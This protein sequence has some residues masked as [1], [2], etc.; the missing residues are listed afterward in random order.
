MKKIMILC[1]SLFLLVACGKPSPIKDINE[2]IQSLLSSNNN[3]IHYINNLSSVEAQIQKAFDT[4]IN[5]ELLNDENSELLKI[6]NQQKLDME[7]LESYLS[8]FEN[9]TTI[10]NE[11]DL[12]NLEKGNDELEKL[13]AS[14]TPLSETIKTSTTSF[15]EQFETTSKMVEIMKQENPSIQD[16]NDSLTTLNATIVKVHE[17]LNKLGEQNAVFQNALSNW[18]ESLKSEEEVNT[19]QENEV[20]NETPVEPV[21]EEPVVESVK[22]EYTLDGNFMVRHLDTSKTDKLVLLTF[23]D[24]VQPEGSSYSLEIAKVL[25]EKGVYGLFFV[26]GMFI[27]SDFGKD[28]LKQI[29]DLGH[30]IGNHTYSHPYL[31]TLDLQQTKDELVNTN[32]IIESVITDKVKFFRPSYGIMGDYSQQVIDELN[33]TWMNWTYGYDWEADYMNGDSLADIMVNTP[34]LSDGA[35]LLMHDRKWTA[36]AIGRIVDGLIAKGYTIVDPRLIEVGGQ[37]Q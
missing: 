18:D 17:G 35:N 29:H 9:A 26:N 1:A 25:K 24:V 32:N 16:L 27:E 2:T 22:A 7:N 11:I 28:Q 6:V 8:S 23:D 19:P 36:E 21:I 12:E 37:T 10:L 20:V 33:M 5:Q 3:I 31:N 15:K 14:L 30:T 34:Y 4:D 13:K